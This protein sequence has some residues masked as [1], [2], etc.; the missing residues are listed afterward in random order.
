M[1]PSEDGG[2]EKSSAYGGAYLNLKKGGE[3]DDDSVHS[4]RDYL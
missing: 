2:S 1:F 4:R 3:G